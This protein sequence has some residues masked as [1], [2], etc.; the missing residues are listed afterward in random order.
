MES[1]SDRDHGHVCWFDSQAAF[2]EVYTGRITTSPTQQ[3]ISAVIEDRASA[4]SFRYT[5]IYAVGLAA[6]CDAFLPATCL[7]RGRL[8]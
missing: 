2:R 7:K 3:F 1:Q 6:L 8:G 5:R 4:F